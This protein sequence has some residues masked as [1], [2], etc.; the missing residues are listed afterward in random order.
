MF[1]DPHLSEQQ[2][3]LHDNKELLPL[4]IRSNQAQ[5]NV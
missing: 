3:G 5:G 2:A 1:M 4:P